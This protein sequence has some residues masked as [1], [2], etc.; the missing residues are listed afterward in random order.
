MPLSDMLGGGHLGGKIDDITGQEKQS[1]QEGGT[2]DTFD[3]DRFTAWYGDNLQAGE[4]RTLAEYVVE[5]QT[6][7]NIG[8]GSA[9]VEETVGRF[10]SVFMDGSGSETVGMVRVQTSNSHDENTDTEVSAIASQRLSNGSIGNKREQ[11][12]IPE[13][14]N[15]DK[16]GT[17][18]KIKVLFK[19]K[20]SSSGTN[21]SKSASTVLYDMT[22][23]D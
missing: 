23:Y 16:V 8:H 4:W 7:Y 21:I 13:N 17:D 5:P 9:P 18:S 12:A 14:T 15:T 19:L 3:E 22:R 10:Y 2:K 20:E 11:Y 1:K 6:A